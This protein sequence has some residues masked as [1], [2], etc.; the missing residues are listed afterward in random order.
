MRAF[1]L[2]TPALALC[3]GCAGPVPVDAPA[4]PSPTTQGPADLLLVLEAGLR[5]DLG[6]AAGAEAAFAE[7]LGRAPDV[8][9]AQAC[10]QSVHGFVSTGSVLTGRYPSAIPLCSWGVGAGQPPWCA[11][12]PV[13]A[14]TLPGVL[15]IYGYHTAYATTPPRPREAGSIESEFRD[16]VRGEGSTPMRDVVDRALAWWDAH[17]DAPRLL[18]VE[19]DLAASLSAGAPPSGT[20]DPGGV[21]RIAVA[22]RDTAADRGREIGRLLAGTLGGSGRAA[23]AIVTSTHG[24]NLGERTGTPSMPLVPVHHDILLERTMHVPM[25]LFSSSGAS[26]RTDDDVVELIDI[27]PTFARLAEV[28]PPAGLP[29]RDLLTAPPDPDRVCYAEFGD[30]IAV[31][32][33]SHLLMARL[34]MHGGTTLDPEITRRL[35]EAPAGATSFALHDI[36]AD[37][38]QERELLATEEATGKALYREMARIRQ[39]SGATP[40]D[41]LSPERIEALRKTGA[42]SYF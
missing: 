42:Q 18:V 8:R 11:S 25:L 24:V 39:T 30:M 15:A 28:M 31:R 36:A 1:A 12:L 27:A 38:L 3:T 37:P 23:Y 34:W 16:T 33:R 40:E 41:A 26:P 14:P 7:A 6:G 4:P 21:A 2:G 20:P 22:Y 35:L 32:S 9:F 10:P 5:S 17:A 19:D 29:G 13:S